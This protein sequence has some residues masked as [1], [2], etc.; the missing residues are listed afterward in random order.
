MHIPGPK[1]LQEPPVLLCWMGCGSGC[2]GWRARGPPYPHHSQARHRW[3]PLCRPRIAPKTNS[4][5]NS[6]M[7][8]HW[9]WGSA[10]QPSLPALQE[11]CSL[12]NTLPPHRKQHKAVRGPAVPLQ[13]SEWLLGSCTLLW[14]AQAVCTARRVH[15]RCAG[16]RAQQVWGPQGGP[17]AAVLVVPSAPAV[18]GAVESHMLLLPQC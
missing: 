3:Q 8:S 2:T 15:R 1:G 6:G 11:P 14:T 18:A 5:I 17:A 4:Q 7:D 9:R 16:P 10:A 13:K 12:S